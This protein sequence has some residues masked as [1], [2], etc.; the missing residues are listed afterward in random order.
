MIRL[1]VNGEAHQI[2]ADGETPLLWVLRDNLGF[3]GVKYGCGIGECGTCTVLIDGKAER[4]CTITAE[5]VQ[6]REIITIEGLP[7]DHPVKQTWIS[8]QVPQC[9]YCQPGMI[10]QAVDVLT[11]QPDASK[12][13]MAE[14][15]DDV[16]CRCG[17]HPRVLKAMELAAGKMKGKGGAS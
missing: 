7:D 3:T 12:Q 16:V 11:S 6:G 13:E 10:L 14:A 1:K 2:D 8:E 5:S 15:M 9:G 17:T 4:S